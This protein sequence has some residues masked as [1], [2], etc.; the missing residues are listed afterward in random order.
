MGM[1]GKKHK[2]RKGVRRD[3]DNKGWEGMNISILRN[4]KGYENI[5]KNGKGW[6]IL[7]DTGMNEKGGK[8][9]GLERMEAM[10]MNKKEWQ[11]LGK[12][13]KGRKGVRKD[14]VLRDRKGWG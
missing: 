2:G 12:K 10:E 3:E 8:P 9:E 11:R 13:Y 4:R 6:E 1:D 14:E 5:K 7:E